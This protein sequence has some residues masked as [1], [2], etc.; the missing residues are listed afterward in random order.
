MGDF[1]S[2]ITNSRTDMKPENLIKELN[3]VLEKHGVEILNAIK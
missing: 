1:T 3:E 2:F